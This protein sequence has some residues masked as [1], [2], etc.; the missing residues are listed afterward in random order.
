MH[1]TG[2]KHSQLGRGEMSLAV[3]AEDT[4]P[5]VGVIGN[6]AGKQRIAY[7]PSLHR[8]RV[9][10]ESSSSPVISDKRGQ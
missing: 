4:Q 10:P 6:I 7:I 2:H 3:K 5:S 9:H 1:K 8:G